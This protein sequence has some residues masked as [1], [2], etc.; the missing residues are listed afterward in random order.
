MKLHTALYLLIAFI[1][2]RPEQCYDYELGWKGSNVKALNDCDI[3]RDRSSFL[4]DTVVAKTQCVTSVLIDFEDSD[5]AKTKA[6]PYLRPGEEI[7]LG[8]VPN[9]CLNHDV[10][11]RVHCTNCIGTR[12][13][14]TK[15]KLN[16]MKCYDMNR[17]LNFTINEERKTAVINNEYFHMSNE[18][19]E[20]CM[21]SASLINSNGTEIDNAWRK[22]YEV[23]VDRCNN[24]T[25]MLIYTFTSARNSE[26]EKLEKVI[27]VPWD[28]EICFESN[29][30]NQIILASAVASALV[31]TI[32]LVTIGIVSFKRAAAV[33]SN[34]N[35]D[36]DRNPVYGTYSRGWEDDGDYGDGDVVE[37]KDNNPVY[38]T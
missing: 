25:F 24:E 35:V 12:I 17:E 27:D 15:F 22:E 23:T 5:K 16:P 1:S 7:L 32:I 19:V 34:V 9:K 38:G 33:K 28:P 26:Y 30:E 31:F 18:Y 11:I 13:Y 2:V 3:L 4:L 14:E 37:L 10:K 8:R 21:L 6:G 36:T 20:K 29:K